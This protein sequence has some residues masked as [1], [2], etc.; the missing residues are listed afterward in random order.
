MCNNGEQG[1][2]VEGVTISEINNLDNTSIFVSKKA[3]HELIL[4]KKQLES[5]LITI[6]TS[7]YKIKEEIVQLDLKDVSPQ[8]LIMKLP[9]L[10][11]DK[12]LSESINS[13]LKPEVFAIIEKYAKK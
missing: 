9:K 11:M 8:K 12:N 2:V 6:C 3:L 5:D 1:F 4:Q 13:T 10:I 7:A